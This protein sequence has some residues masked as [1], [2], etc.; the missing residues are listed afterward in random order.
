MCLDE[1]RDRHRLAACFFGTTRFEDFVERMQI[2]APAVS[3]A[4]RQ[5]EAAGILTR[6]PYREPGSRERREYLLTDAGEDLLPIFLALVRWGDNYLQAGRTPLEFV[7]DA[8]GRPVEVL[9]SSDAGTVGTRSAD[10]RVRR[11]I[12]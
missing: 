1:L 10:I 5:L 2:S 11:G 12:R 7:D 4:L 6:V 3:R 9:V 8:T